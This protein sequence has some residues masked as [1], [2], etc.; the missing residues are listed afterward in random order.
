MHDLPRHSAVS[1]RRPTRKASTDA[2][3]AIYAM[4]RNTKDYHVHFQELFNRQVCRK[5]VMSNGETDEFF[6]D[7]LDYSE[8]KR[9]WK[10]VYSDAKIDPDLVPEPEWLYVKDILESLVVEE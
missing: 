10:V 8:A 5:V 9:K 7:I 4:S 3:S 6:G 1:R 2:S